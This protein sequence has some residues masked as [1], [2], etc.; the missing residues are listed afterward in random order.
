MAK[1]NFQAAVPS[2]T[3]LNSEALAQSD[4]VEVPS[5]PHWSVGAGAAIASGSIAYYLG[6]YTEYFI[7]GPLP[8]EAPIYAAFVSI[9]LL[10]TVSLRSICGRKEKKVKISGILNGATSWFSVAAT[11]TGLAFGVAADA[12]ILGGFTAGGGVLGYVLSRTGKKKHREPCGQLLPCDTWICPSCFHIISSDEHIENKS[13]WTILEA[14]Q[15]LD[16]GSARLNVMQALAFMQLA[17]LLEAGIAR[18][19]F[20]TFWDP[21]AIRNSIKDPKKFDQFAREWAQFENKEGKLDG[22]VDTVLRKWVVHTQRK[23]G[24]VKFGT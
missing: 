19:G 11:I 3:E 16:T 10:S 9:S 8:S 18:K 13:Y 12:A 20:Q 23:S 1:E 7:S 4:S 2:M 6:S 24:P 21:N 15:H 14:C 17:E 22:D 5:N